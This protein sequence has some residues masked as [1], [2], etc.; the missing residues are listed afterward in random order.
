[1]RL[2]HW[3][4]SLSVFF[5]AYAHT[6][7]I[8]VDEVDPELYVAQL[9][10]TYNSL[11]SDPLIK[12]GQIKEFLKRR[13]LVDLSD[14]DKKYLTKILVHGSLLYDLNWK[15]EGSKIHIDDNRIYKKPLDIDF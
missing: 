14:K 5:T 2:G 7:R 15:A 10:K 3:F 11:M 8:E 13:E 1:M 4:I 12:K 9:A 6:S